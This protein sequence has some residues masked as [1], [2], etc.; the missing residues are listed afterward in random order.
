M[1]K[2]DKAILDLL[3]TDSTVAVNEIASQVGLSATPCWRR[4]Q[5]LEEAG[6]ID[7][8]VALLNA[9][10][11]NL[12]VTVFV[13][14]RTAEHSVEWL[15]DFHGAVAAIPEVLEVHRMAGDTDYLL[16][17]VVPHIAAYDGVYKR[18]IQI[19]RLMDVSSNFS[20]ECIKSTTR[21]PL[22]YLD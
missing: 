4:I 20:M 7:R 19:A 6:F 3:Q 15:K 8:R 1:D 13:S 21:L 2:F 11:L 22:N 14:I 18:L 5:K 17:I 16:R 10:R 9:A 12:G